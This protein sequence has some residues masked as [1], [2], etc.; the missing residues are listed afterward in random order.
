MIGRLCIETMVRLK[1]L[2][3]LRTWHIE[4]LFVAAALILVVVLTGRRDSLVEWLGAVAVYLTFGHASVSFRLSEAE[5]RRSTREVQCYRKARCY[6]LGK[7]A[8]WFLYFTVLGLWS[9][10]VGVF[11]FLVYPLWRY[12]WINRVHSAH[13]P[14]AET[15]SDQREPV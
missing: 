2:T 11:V 8:C 7:E 14:P 9:A 3:G 12:A 1:R 6:F 10:L 13:Q 4:S 15:H 5:E